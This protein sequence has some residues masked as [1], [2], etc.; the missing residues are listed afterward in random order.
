MWSI[1]FF[2]LQFSCPPGIHPA[3][4][5]VLMYSSSFLNAKL[6]GSIGIQAAIVMFK[7]RAWSRRSPQPEHQY[8][9]SLY[10]PKFPNY[11]SIYPV[12]TKIALY[13]NV[14]VRIYFPQDICQDLPLTS[15]SLFQLQLLFQHCPH[16][17]QS[18]DIHDYDVWILTTTMIIIKDFYDFYA[19]GVI[20]QRRWSTLELDCH[21]G[22]KR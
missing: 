3:I 12:C 15:V 7:Q 11:A 9:K 14:F 5:V 6:L 18:E 16:D 10:V 4:I 21:L 20:S 8:K 2:S 1:I 19:I 17:R 22:G 13:S